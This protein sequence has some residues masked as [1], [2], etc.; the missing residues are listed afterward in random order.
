MDY[1]PTSSSD[2]SQLS[3][4]SGNPTPAKSLENEPPKDGSPT[5]QCGKG[6]LD[7]SI[8]PNTPEK[9]IA[10]MQ[11]SL[12]RTLALLEIRPEWEQR[13]EAASTGKSS[14]LLASF[15]PATF[16]LKTSQQSFL[17]D[18]EPYSQTLPRWGWMQDGF[19]YGHPM[20]E[21]RMGGIGGFCLPTPRASDGF[22]WTR[23]GKRDSQTSISKTVL[24]FGDVRAI[25][26]FV[27]NGMSPNQTADVLEM[28]MG[29]PRGF[30]VLKELETQSYRSKPQQPGDCL[31]V[32]K[33]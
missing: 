20:S 2:T 18:S 27:W 8:H 25:Y 32:D 7:C 13:H 29:F 28:T 10:S 19:V 1:L 22:A 24:R 26:P 4:L 31:E 5:C 16:S 11:D 15:D 9:W 14:G 33:C 30:T 17:T 21:R 6:M 23:I 3:L 12:A